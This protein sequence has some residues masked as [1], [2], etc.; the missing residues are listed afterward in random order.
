MVRGASGCWKHYRFVKGDALGAS[1]S[2][3]CAVIVSSARFTV[4]SIVV[5]ELASSAN[6]V[7]AA[8]TSAARR[9]VSTIAIASVSSEPAAGP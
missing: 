3:T 2:F 6:G 4:A 5:D 7:R 1:D 9:A 8:A